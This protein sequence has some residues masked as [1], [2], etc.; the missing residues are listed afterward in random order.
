[1]SCNASFS[2]ILWTTLVLSVVSAA[3]PA[4]G[5]APAAKLSADLALVPPD[6]IGFVHIRVGDLLQSEIGKAVQR[7]APPE[8]LKAINDE[9]ATLDTSLTELDRI[10]LVAVPK[11]AAWE[12]LEGQRADPEPGIVVI[13][14]TVKPYNRAKLLGSRLG[15]FTEEKYRG[16]SLYR[17]RDGG[18]K[19]DAMYLASDRAYV[20][21]DDVEQLRPLVRHAIR[22]RSS[23]AL[24]SALATAAG[25]EK[26]AVVAG[27]NPTAAL[28]S[29][30]VRGGG[31]W[32]FGF[33]GP[34]ALARVIEA[35]SATLSLD[36]ASNKVRMI[37]EVDYGTEFMA[38][39]ALP[40]AR[41]VL[42]F[43]QDAV[44]EAVDG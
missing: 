36:D 4:V 34:M 10:T 32:P 16:R 44:A 24:S 20:I 12:L 40:T 28:P 18:A 23:G 1:M 11:S 27:L 9:V 42:N 29:L 35:E 38:R 37:L 30:G 5:Q 17:A 3:P 13:V 6:A 41:S 21:A 14:S 25:S 22:P 39:R 33:F 19:L 2:R 7:L 43:A 15:D 8:L 26:H 31:D